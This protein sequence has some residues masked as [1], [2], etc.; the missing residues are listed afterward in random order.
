MIAL[1]DVS[2][3]GKEIAVTHTR[4]VSVETNW[5]GGIANPSLAGLLPLPSGQE[6]AVF[7]AP[8]R[9]DLRHDAGRQPVAGLNARSL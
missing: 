4:F 8:G 7:D 6:A 1:G 3:T 5:D 2:V 9:S